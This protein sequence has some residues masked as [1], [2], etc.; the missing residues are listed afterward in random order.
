MPDCRPMLQTSDQ[1]FRTLPR[2]LSGHPS[3]LRTAE[4]QTITKSTQIGHKLCMNRRN[5]PDL[6]ACIAMRA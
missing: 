4:A 3:R 6:P 1:G 2:P 5:R